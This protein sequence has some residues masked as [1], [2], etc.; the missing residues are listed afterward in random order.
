[1]FPKMKRRVTFLKGGEAEGNIF[2]GKKLW[3]NCLLYAGWLKN[4]LRFQGAQPDQVQVESSCCCFP[5]ELVS[6]VCPRELVRF[7]PWHV[8]CFRPIRKRIWVGRY[9]KTYWSDI[10]STRCSIWLDKIVFTAGQF[11]TCPAVNKTPAIL[12]KSWNPAIL[13]SEEC[14]EIVAFEIIS[15]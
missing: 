2:E 10:R 12:I 5:G 1:M 13:N 9:N 8:T 4:L 15:Q 3:G 6:F 7:D 11:A 14:F